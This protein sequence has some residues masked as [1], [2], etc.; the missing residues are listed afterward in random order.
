MGSGLGL[1]KCRKS[2]PCTPIAVSGWRS[3]RADINC[4]VAVQMCYVVKGGIRLTSPGLVWGDGYSHEHNRDLSK[5]EFRLVCAVW[6]FC[7]G[8]NVTCMG[9]VGSTTHKKKAKAGGI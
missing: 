3:Q 1:E 6:S 8:H 5:Y 7:C 2:N 9:C 4:I